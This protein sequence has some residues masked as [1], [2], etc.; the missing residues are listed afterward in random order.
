MGAADLLDDAQLLFERAQAHKREFNQILA[1]GPGRLWTLKRTVSPDGSIHSAE[2]VVDRA[3][4]RRTKPILADVAN[5]LRHALDHVT[6]AARRSARLPHSRNL[7]L[8]IAAEDEAYAAL[9]AKVAPLL[10][11][12]WID[13]FNAA[14]EQ[15][16]PYLGYLDIIRSISNDAKHWKLAVG[17]AGA[18][19]V[20]WSA[21]G[22]AQHSIV[23]IPP[24]HFADHDGFP[25]W[26]GA[27]PF[28]NVAILIVAGYRLM[29]TDADDADVESV[30][31]TGSNFVA[32]V[33][34]RSRQLF[35]SLPP[36]A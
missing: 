22:S 18:L 33:I 16:R 36:P 9:V 5:N 29:S 8:P 12:P 4:Q 31:S 1:A 27:D 3:V 14:R 35:A 21:P 30:L 13:L 26:S 7:Y 28:P 2:L 11:Q 32:D 19:A 10:D 23:Q 20:Q 24:D 17:T 25:F 6:A 15:H 34:A